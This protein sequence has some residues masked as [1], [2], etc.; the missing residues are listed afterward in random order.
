S[1]STC[2]AGPSSSS[3]CSSSAGATSSS[4]RSTTSRARSPPPSSCKT[5]C[6]W[7]AR[8]CCTPSAS[9]AS[10]SSGAS[11][12]M[13]ISAPSRRSG[14]TTRS[15]SPTC[16]ATLGNRAAVA[17]ADARL[18]ALVREHRA[19]LQRLSNKRLDVVEEGMRRI[20]RELH[21]GTCQ[22]LMAIKLDLLLLERQLPADAAALHGAVRTVRDHVLDVMHSV[23]QM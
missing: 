23:R 20:S 21:D 2:T 16:T 19:E 9:N 22:A 7:S 8:A 5:C 10:G 1:S 15:R 4:R 17:I 12:P 14:A 18:Y 11:R 13:A 3:A 6:G